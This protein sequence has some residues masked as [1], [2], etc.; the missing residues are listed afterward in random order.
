VKGVLVAVNVLVENVRVLVHALG[1]LERGRAARLLE[2]TWPDADLGAQTV[3]A[4]EVRR[5]HPGRILG[6]WELKAIA[7][8]NCRFREVVLLLRR[9]TRMGSWPAPTP[10]RRRSGPDEEEQECRQ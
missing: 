1:D 6:G 8:A 4:F 9:R 10:A 5:R 2:H 7:L 3:D